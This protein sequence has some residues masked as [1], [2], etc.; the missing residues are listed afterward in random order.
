MSRKQRVLRVISA[1]RALDKDALVPLL[2]QSTGLSREGVL[3][4]L[5]HHLETSPSEEEIATFLSAAHES[6]R[7]TV[8]LSRVVFAGALRAIA[9]AA[10]IAPR[11]VVRPSHREPHFA[12]ALVSAIDDASITLDETVDVSSITEGE[13]HIYGGDDAI[14][15]V[16]S[17]ARVPV[18]AHGPGMGVAIVGEGADLDRAADAIAS[19]VVPFDQRGCLSPRVVVA[20]GNAEAFANALVG[21]LNKAEIPRGTLSPEERAEAKR[22]TEA[23]RFLGTAYEGRDSMVG[24]SDEL[25]I[26]PPGRH[27]HVVRDPTL[28]ARVAN[29]ITAVGV[30]DDALARFAPAHARISHLGKMQHPPL[31]GPVDRRTR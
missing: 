29:A 20:M 24:V 26:P 9:W 15:R 14:A 30:S 13:I 27:V 7:V 1:A 17:Q 31:D 4:A 11:V 23:C 3:L 19:D 16:R 18:R 6:S 25:V 5:E 2:T 22:Y 28:L 21:S 12:R 10:A 8:I